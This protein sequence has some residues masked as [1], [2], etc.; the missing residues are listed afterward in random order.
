M[1]SDS[2]GRRLLSANEWIEVEDIIGSHLLETTENW[3][4]TVITLPSISFFVHG[5]ADDFDEV[6]LLRS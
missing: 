2:I 1:K 6:T 5:I 4:S 3:L